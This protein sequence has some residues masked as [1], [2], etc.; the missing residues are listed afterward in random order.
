MKVACLG[1]ALANATW[2]DQK[3]GEK[4][5]G[6]DVNIEGKAF[7]VPCKNIDDIYEY[8]EIVIIGD[9]RVFEK[10]WYFKGA[11]VR[12]ASREDIA[13]FGEPRGSGLKR[14]PPATNGETSGTTKKGS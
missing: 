2:V 10:N 12:V 4:H 8:D 6:L 1:T 5:E 11:E 3:T 13:F 7:K 9:L 14:R